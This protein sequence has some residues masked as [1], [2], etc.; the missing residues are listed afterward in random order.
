[1]T[2][3]YERFSSGFFSLGSSFLLYSL[4]LA[5]CF[6]GLIVY[7]SPSLVSSKETCDECTLLMVGNCCFIDKV[8]I[9]RLPFV[10]FTEILGSNWIR[11][12][13]TLYRCQRQLCQSTLKV[14]FTIFKHYRTSIAKFILFL[15]L[16]Y[17]AYNEIIFII[18]G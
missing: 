4:A 12:H 13:K 8:K 9:E 11:W 7:I 15:A 6:L 2:L 16:S 3:T 1:M 10:S 17:T 18:Q 14:N 5:G